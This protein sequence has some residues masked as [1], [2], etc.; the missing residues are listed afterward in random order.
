MTK[1]L[2]GLIGLALLGSGPFAGQTPAYASE[3]ASGA[4]AGGNGCCGCCAACGCCLVPVCQISCTTKKVTEYKYSCRCED[5]CVP[6][7]VPLCKRRAACETSDDGCPRDCSGR[8][9]VHEVKQLVKHPVTK[10][11]PVRKCTVQWV[12]P[13]CSSGDRVDSIPTPPATPAAPVPAP[14]APMPKLPSSPKAANAAL[15]ASPPNPFRLP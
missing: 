3:A 2:V 4:N 13:K 12:C 9:T 7:V 11:V 15:P 6:G 1:Y 10:E 8:C 14:P 5:M